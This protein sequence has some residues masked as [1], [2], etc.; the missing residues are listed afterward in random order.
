M[1]HADPPAALTPV[2]Q[3][4]ALGSKS[5]SPRR[6]HRLGGYNP[7][8]KSRLFTLLSALSLLISLVACAL[9]IRSY[10]LSD[11]IAHT[12]VQIDTR[13]G[14]PWNKITHA[15]RSSRGWFSDLEYRD[16]G[17][18]NTFDLLDKDHAAH[19]IDRPQST[20]TTSRA[21]LQMSSFATR[22]GAEICIPYLLPALLFLIAPARWLQL[23]IR[24]LRHL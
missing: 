13:T 6:E 21:P 18:P 5:R 15:F 12:I 19:S 8:V 2:R 3:L 4:I 23:F 16:E 1:R 7:F 20:W 10:W 24:S 14:Q 22:Y 17:Q 9:W 11:E